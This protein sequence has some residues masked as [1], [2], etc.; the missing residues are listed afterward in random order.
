MNATGSDDAAQ[1]NGGTDDI[2]AVKRLLSNFRD[3]L[4]TLDCDL[5]SLYVALDGPSGAVAQLADTVC[6][7][8]WFVDDIDIRGLLPDRCLSAWP[9]ATTAG[10]ATRSTA[11]SSITAPDSTM[12]PI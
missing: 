1:A 9:A 10:T 7:R 3:R 2:A 11:S 5:Y 12:Q 8:D 6:D 4:Q